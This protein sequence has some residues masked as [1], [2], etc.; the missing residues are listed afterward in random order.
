MQFVP[1]FSPGLG[2]WETDPSQNYA[3]DNRLYIYNCITN[4]YEFEK[5][6]LNVKIIYIYNLNIETFFLKFITICYAIVMSCNVNDTLEQ[7][8]DFFRKLISV[9]A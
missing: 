7:L 9:A 8:N 6:G 5:K 4:R 1:E 2:W 3:L